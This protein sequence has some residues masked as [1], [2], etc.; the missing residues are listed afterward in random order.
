MDALQQLN[1]LFGNMSVSTGTNEINRIRELLSKPGNSSEILNIFSKYPTK[2]ILNRMTYIKSIGYALVNRECINAIADFLGDS[3]TIEI[4][5]GSG[6]LTYLLK[7]CR[8]VDIIATDSKSESHPDWIKFRECQVFDTT[9]DKL[10]D[11]YPD[12]TALV[13]SWPKSYLKSLID[14]LPN[15]ITKIVIIGEGY[16]GCTDCFYYSNEKG[17]LIYEFIPGEHTEYSSSSSSEE[18]EDENEDEEEEVKYP[19][20]EV[21]SEVELPRFVECGDVLSFY[22]RI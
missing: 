9:K 4:G 10:Q 13:V 18:E 5:A 19:F 8:G 1:L 7:K 16:G 21:D 22:E 20:R 11:K 3:K 15:A 17:S 2:S 6:F 14:N 12:A